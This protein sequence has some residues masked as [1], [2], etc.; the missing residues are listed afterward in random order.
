MSRKLRRWQVLENLVKTHGFT[1]LAEIGVFKGQTAAHLL[2]TCPSLH[3]IGVDHW[4]PG[5]PA[6]DIPEERKKQPGDNG[7]RSYARHDLAAYR[8]SVEALAMRYAGRATIIPLPSIEAAK[9]VEDGSLDA[10]FIDGD[11]TLAGVELDIQAW[12][13]KVR[14]G[15]FVC[16][17]DWN[18]PS[19]AGVIDLMCPG[20]EKHDDSVWS[21]PAEGVGKQGRVTRR[22]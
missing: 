11:H 22:A 7:Y 19:V 9:Q 1:S 21:I 8:R 5:D 2:K 14:P 6:F 16:G 3:W 4:T 12:T 18:A 17:H 20:Y 15:G 13:P 10:V